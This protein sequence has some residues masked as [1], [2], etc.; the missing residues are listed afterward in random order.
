MTHDPN[1]APPP[2]PCL[3]LGPFPILS[4][5]IHSGGWTVWTL[6][7]DGLDKQFFFAGSDDHSCGTPPHIHAGPSYV[8]PHSHG[9]SS[10]LL[11]LAGG[12]LPQGHS[13]YNSNQSQKYLPLEYILIKIK[14]RCTQK[15]YGKKT[16]RALIQYNNLQKKS[17]IPIFCHHIFNKCKRVI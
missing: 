3:R 12:G 1:Y 15:L 6:S 2:D 11:S 13:P 16:K 9:N 4:K 17:P 10:I 8:L 7:M 5:P 14:L